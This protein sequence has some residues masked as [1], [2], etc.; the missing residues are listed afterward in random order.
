[1]AGR[2]K[3]IYKACK[4]TAR[5]TTRNIL[6]FYLIAQLQG[7]C[8]CCCH[9]FSYFFHFDRHCVVWR[10]WPL[11]KAYRI[12]NVLPSLR[13]RYGESIRALQGCDR[14]APTP[15]PLM[16]KR[17]AVWQ[18]VSLML[19]RSYPGRITLSVGWHKRPLTL[20]WHCGQS[21][22]TKCFIKTLNR[23]SQCTFQYTKIWMHWSVV[24]LLQVILTESFWPHQYLFFHGLSRLSRI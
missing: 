9:L 8:S 18:W 5:Q 13:N 6:Q 4:G 1:M 7:L 12:W 14:M 15:A 10:T 2:K 24:F 3:A 20:W 19:L 16:S 23:S 11:L 17:M 22:M 21:M